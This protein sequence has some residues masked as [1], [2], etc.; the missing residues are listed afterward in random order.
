MTPPEE[1]RRAADLLELAAKATSTREKDGAYCQAMVIIAQILDAMLE[2]EL[3]YGVV[4]PYLTSVLG[5]R[6]HHS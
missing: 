3:E 6:R 1:L 4:A 5:P 2:V